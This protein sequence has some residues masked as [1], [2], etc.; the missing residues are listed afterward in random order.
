MYYRR[1]ILLYVI[2][3]FAKQ[4]IGKLKLQK[5]LFL[6]CQEQLIRSFDFTPYKYGCYSFQAAK[7]LSVLESHYKLITEKR[8]Q[9]FPNQIFSDELK[10][11]EKQIL[12]TLLKKFKQKDDSEI[13][14]YVYYH[15]PYYSIKSEWRMTVEQAQSQKSE[16]EAVKAQK[17]KCLF[18]IGYEGQS[19]D[20]C[21]NQLLK[22][23]IT[24]LCD[25]RRNPLSMKYGFSKSQLNK[26]CANLDIGYEH[27]PELGIPSQKRKNLNSKLDYQ[28]L[29][30]NYRREL[31]GKQNGL[32]RVLDLLH[33]H[34]RIAIMCFEKSHQDCHRHC[35]SDY[36][37]KEHNV[38]CQHL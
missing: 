38:V 14:N 19:I 24:L 36:L 34:H 20:A 5:L 33:R 9:W 7:D 3:A 23:N 1:K 16:N 11:S 27:I 25:V 26:Y 13:V 12:D 15:Y 35:I 22:R 4:G 29:F 30:K 32:S 17:Q 18:T 8:D 2:S 6:F 28:N 37:Q 21:L 10:S 31:P